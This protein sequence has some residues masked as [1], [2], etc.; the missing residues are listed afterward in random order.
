MATH[1]TSQVLAPSRMEVSRS[2]NPLLLEIAE[3]RVPVPP[4][5]DY[6]EWLHWRRTEG[7]R[8]TKTGG[9]SHTT[10]GAEE[11]VL[12]K[13]VLAELYGEEWKTELKE[14]KEAELMADQE[15]GLPA[16]RLQE[17]GSATPVGARGSASET[18]GQ[19]PDVSA[20]GTGGP[21]AAAA[22]ERPEPGAAPEARTPA[23]ARTPEQ[24]RVGADH[25]PGRASIIPIGSGG[26]SGLATP[27]SLR[28]MLEQEFDPDRESRETWQSRIM[29]GIAQMQ[30][31]GSAMND[32]DIERI[33]VKGSYADKLKGLNLQQQLKTLKRAFGEVLLAESDYE[34]QEYNARLNG[35]IEMLRARGTNMSR[36][37]NKLFSTT[38]P[39]R[40]PAE[41]SPARFE[42][43]G[44]LWTPA[45]ERGEDSGKAQEG[46]PGVGPDSFEKIGRAHV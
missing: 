43:R 35:I 16:G 1:S 38:E 46:E 3:G 22:L 34:P 4:L 32:E 39:S 19:R 5:C 13:A 26:S 17:G 10:T 41:P 12:W 11:S 37:V 33:V 6:R 15:L 31:L 9:D 36:S 14:Q 21:L 44:S 30:A 27:V 7:K 42:E 18:R 25:L 40:A 45:P 2:N 24:A 20:V 28:K 29:R 23:G 8:P